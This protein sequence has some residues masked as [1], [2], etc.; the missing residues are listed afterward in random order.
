VVGDE[1]RL[2]PGIGRDQGGQVGKLAGGSK[3]ELVM[4]THKRDSAHVDT[5]RWEGRG[6]G[7][8]KV[9]FFF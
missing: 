8:M 6:P 7:R 9:L 1:G 4:V 5:V 2:V 3:N